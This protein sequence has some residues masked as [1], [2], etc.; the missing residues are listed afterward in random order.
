MRVCSNRCLDE[1]PDRANAVTLNEREHRDSEADGKQQWILSPGRFHIRALNDRAH[2]D[3]TLPDLA[4]EDSRE[5]LLTDVNV[6]LIVVFH[7]A[8]FPCRIP[9]VQNF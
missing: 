1:V 2:A 6:I 8:K 5:C 4:T 9:V 7:V 3:G